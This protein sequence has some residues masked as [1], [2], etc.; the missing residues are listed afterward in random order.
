MSKSR[1]F[2]EVV[3]KIASAFEGKK[4]LMDDAANRLGGTAAEFGSADRA[5]IFPALPKVPILLLFWDRE[6]EFSARAS[7][8]VDRGILDYLD[9]E[10]IVFLAEAF[11]N[12]LQGKDL[13]EVIP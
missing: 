10:A 12:R 4:E 11:A 3:E 13:S 9:H 1:S 2:E 6:D 7:L 8:L 5:Y